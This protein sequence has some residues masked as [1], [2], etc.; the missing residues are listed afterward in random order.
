MAEVDSHVSGRSGEQ[1]KAMG[2]CSKTNRRRHV[3]TGRKSL[4]QRAWTGI[5]DEAA[6]FLRRIIHPVQRRWEIDSLFARGK[7][8]IVPTGNRWLWPFRIN[9]QCNASACSAAKIATCSRDNSRSR[10][11]QAL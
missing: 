5:G 1:G 2:Y 6:D 7:Q 4:V 10:S 11:G 3:H 9:Q 8:R